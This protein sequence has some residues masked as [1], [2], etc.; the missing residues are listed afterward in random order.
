M[1]KVHRVIAIIG[2]VILP[3][4]VNMMLLED[5]SEEGN[6]VGKKYI[7]SDFFLVLKCLNKDERKI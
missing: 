5:V 2:A 4:K 3:K 1:E 6:I 7:N